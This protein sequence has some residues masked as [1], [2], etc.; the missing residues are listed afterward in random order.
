MLCI[1]WGHGLPWPSGQ[2]DALP[3][4]EP[5][6]C[7]TTREG[8]S[9]LTK[10]EFLIVQSQDLP[11]KPAELA[12]PN[13]SDGRLSEA[14]EMTK[15]LALTLRKKTNMCNRQVFTSDVDWQQ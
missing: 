11:D 13:R 5:E 2:T 1:D 3:R 12:G 15:F 14:G 8:D 4:H 9:R 10:I 7:L 6:Q